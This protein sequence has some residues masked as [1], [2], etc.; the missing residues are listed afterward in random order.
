MSYFSTIN[1]G[2]TVHTV[3]RRTWLLK[4]LQNMIVQESCSGV[5][6][7]SFV[8]YDNTLLLMGINKIKQT[9]L[10]NFKDKPEKDITIHYIFKIC[11]INTTQLY[12]LQTI[13]WVAVYFCPPLSDP[14]SGEKKIPEYIF[15]TSEFIWVWN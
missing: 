3:L 4:L 10:I 5:Y 9:L 1:L 13:R 12:I 14:S 11:I 15:L 6:I 8:L 2:P 7:F